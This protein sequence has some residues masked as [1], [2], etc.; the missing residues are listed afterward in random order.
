MATSRVERSAG[1]AARAT[2]Q[3]GLGREKTYFFAPEPG[4]VAALFDEVA[5]EPPVLLD[6]VAFVGLGE[7]ELLDVEESLEVE[8]ESDEVLLSAGAAAFDDELA[9]RLSVL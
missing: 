5:D 2:L 8:L 3:R 7:P 1:E 9:E 4:V 6:S